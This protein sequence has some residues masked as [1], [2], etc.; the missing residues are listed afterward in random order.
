MKLGD[1]DLQELQQA[2]QSERSSWITALREK[3]R[4]RDAKR[5][6]VCVLLALEHV[7][8]KVVATDDPVLSP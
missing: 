2:L 8:E 4:D 7:L 6:T 5:M 1:I 3:G